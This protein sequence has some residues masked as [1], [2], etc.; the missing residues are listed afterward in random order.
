MP[1]DRIMQ[2]LEAGIGHVL[3]LNRMLFLYRGLAHCWELLASHWFL[4]F[5]RYPCWFRWLHATDL[6]ELHHLLAALAHW[7]YWSRGFKWRSFYLG[8]NIKEDPFHQLLLEE[9]LRLKV[10]KGFGEVFRVKISTDGVFLVV[11]RATWA[12]FRL[13]VGNSVSLLSKQCHLRWGQKASHEVTKA[14]LAC[15]RASHV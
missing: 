7:A 2:V 13:L 9:R 12:P 8:I 10:N 5:E 3:E 4:R 1:L 14:D 11:F 6:R 15:N